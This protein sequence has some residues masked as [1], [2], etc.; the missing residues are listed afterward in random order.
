[1]LI[2]I[3]CSIFDKKLFPN[4]WKNYWMIS[5]LEKTLKQKYELIKIEKWIIIKNNQVVI[6]NIN[7]ITNIKL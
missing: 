3:A 7:E 6:K 2:E 4:N 1:M 5:M